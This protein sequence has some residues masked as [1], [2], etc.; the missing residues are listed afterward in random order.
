MSRQKQLTTAERQAL[1][2]LHEVMGRGCSDAALPAY[3][4]LA[5][6]GLARRE[7]T[8]DGSDGWWRTPAGTQALKEVQG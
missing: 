8:A 6:K 3:V 5:R 1:R 2:Q 7:M 4:A